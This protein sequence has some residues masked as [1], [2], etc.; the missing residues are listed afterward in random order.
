LEKK[1]KTHPQTR[2]PTH[3]SVKKKKKNTGPQASLNEKKKHW[4]PSQLNEKK[5]T[6]TKPVERKKNPDPKPEKNYY[7]ICIYKTKKI[8]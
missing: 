7:Y 8:I 1:K 5:N 2:T 6:A 3:K 4:P